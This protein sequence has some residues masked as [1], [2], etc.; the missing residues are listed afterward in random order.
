MGGGG[1]ERGRR[2]MDGNDELLKGLR[3]RAFNYISV[4]ISYQ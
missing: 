2:S 3:V 1:M 4:D